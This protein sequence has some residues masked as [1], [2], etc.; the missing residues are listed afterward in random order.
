MAGASASASVSDVGAIDTT[1]V[2]ITSAGNVNENAAGVT[3]NIALSNAP[4]GA[5]TATVMVGETAHTVDIDAEGNGTLFIATTDSDPYNDGQ[6]VT[7]TVTAINGGNFEATSVA[8]ASASAS[9]SD[10]G[11]INTTTVTLSANVTSIAEGGAITYTASVLNAPQ[12]GA[13]VLTLSN[14]QTITIFENEF[15]GS[16]TVAAPSVTT[17]T[18]EV[19]GITSAAGGNYELLNTSSTVTVRVIDSVPTAGTASAFVDDD[20]LVGGNPASTVGDLDA[21]QGGDTNPSEAIYTGTLA[22]SFGGDGA[23]LIGF[24]S[25]ALVV[26]G[27]TATIGGTGTV[28]TETVTYSWSSSTNT[29][30]ATGPRGVLFTVAVTNQ[31]TGAYKVTLLDN[32]LHASGNNENDA[33]PV[34]LTYTVV[35]GDASTATGT[36]N[37]TFD[38]DTPTFTQIM[39]GIAANQV[40]VLSGTHNIAFGADGKGS[41]NLSGL[42]TVTGLNY[43]TATHNPDGSTTIT[44]GTG[45]NTTGFF[46][47]TVKADGTYDFNLID[48]RPSVDKVVTFGT[49]QGAAGVPVLTIGTGVNAITFTGL[50]G[51]TIKPTSAGFGVNDGN[52]DPGD[53]FSVTFAGNQVDSVS[54]F[55][56]H[57][58]SSALTMNWS[59]NAG[60]SGFASVTA[61]G[62]VTIDPLNDFTSIIFSATGSNG[63]NAKVE[64]FSYKQ[65]LLPPDQVLQ[66]NVSATD[67]DGDVSASQTL[68]IQLLGGAIGAPITG[69]GADESIFGTS[70]SETINGGAGDDTINTGAGN[71]TLIGGT[72]NDT[73]TGGLGADV[74]KW[75]FGDQ[76]SLATPA[77]DHITDFSKAGG[78]KLNL[79]DLLQGENTGS[80]NQYLTFATEGD[81]AVLNV[82]TTANGPVEQ[83]I[84]FDNYTTVAALEAT[85]SDVSG[86]DLIAKMKANGNLITH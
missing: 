39:Q 5:A 43:S 50:G 26:N 6:T 58:G 13:L 35:D 76:G 84:V 11:A 1:T 8:G 25:M 56:K 38:D 70:V 52:L 10:V 17:D 67:S 78:D 37:V 72:G 42:T 29:L 33:G 24:A 16:V 3:F 61:N 23:G 83:K 31:A 65:N 34:A 82:S 45:T 36:L 21:N 86:T 18:N 9:V 48:P 7:A 77:I 47:L 32:V 68:G 57:Q 74:F 80:L 19:V 49:V 40:G 28:G 51:D 81:N 44:A 54:F 79:A 41:I 2:T 30:T 73:L 85:F 12:G 71:D 27:G 66:F 69:S 60:N 64:S 20:G 75:S 63:V 4:Q 53:Q 15:N 59:T 55:V 62:T 46:A 14:N 22:F